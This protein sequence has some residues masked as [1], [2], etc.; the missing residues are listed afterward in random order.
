[1]LWAITLLAADF[2]IETPFYKWTDQEVGKMLTDSPWARKAEVY[3]K[4][5]DTGAGLIIRWQ[6]A[7]PIRQAVARFH[8][9]DEAETS[10]KIAQQLNREEPYYIVG[11]LGLP[12]TLAGDKPEELKSRATLKV[13]SEPPIQ[14]LDI[15]TEKLMNP[16]F[17]VFFFFPKAQ[18]G[19]HLITL[20]D[21]TVEFSFETPLAQ[22]R[23]TF[24]LKD[25]IYKGKL[26]L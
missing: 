2:W 7:V 14:P 12:L 20:A 9:G 24:V 6:T 3:V 4:G 22:I 18:P 8:Y 19:A 13:G 5:K 17:N 23:R 21:E 1:M 15:L 26:E 11:I 10:E 25:L 16:A